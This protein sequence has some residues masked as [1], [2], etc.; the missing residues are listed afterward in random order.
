MHNYYDPGNFTMIMITYTKAQA[1]LAKLILLLKLGLPCFLEN[2]N[3]K[4]A[5]LERWI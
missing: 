4:S 1:L 3:I 5:A 2:K